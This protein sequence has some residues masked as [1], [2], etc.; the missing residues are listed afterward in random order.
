M[1]FPETIALTTKKRST[2]R[3]PPPTPKTGWLPPTSYPNLSAANI[4]GFDVETKEMDFDAGPGW[5]RGKGH[6]VGFSLS[7]QD[8][9]G[10]RGKWYIPVRHE[11]EPEYNLD[12]VNSFNWLRD[13]LGNPSTLKVGANIIYDIGWLAE[14]NVEVKGTLYD[15][16]FAEALLHEDG[17]VGLDHLANKY[18]NR[19]KVTDLLYK[20]CSDA[21]GGDVNSKQR[22]NIYRASP[23]LVGHYGED[24]ADLPIEIIAHQYPLM[25]KEDLLPVFHMECEL[26]PL[27]VAMRRTGVHVD[28]DRAAELKAELTLS[29]QQLNDEIWRMVGFYANVSSGKDLAKAFNILGIPYKITSSGNPSFNKE[30]LNSVEHPFGALIRSVR[31]MQSIRDTFIQSYILDKNANGRV[32][33]SFHPLR[34]DAGGT[35]SGRFSSSDPNLQNIPARTDL[36]KKVRT[37][38]IPDKGHIAW[39]KSDY[40][41]IEYRMLAHFAVGNGSDELRAEY[42]NNPRTDYHD[43][44][45]YRLCPFMGWDHNDAAIRKNYRKPV[46]NINFGLLYGMGLSKLSR[47]LMEYFSGS[48][49]SAQIKELFDAY[50]N[51]NPYVK[52]T[53]D[54]VA[55]F[56]QQNGYIATI[57]GRRSRFNL[58]EPRDRFMDSRPAITYDRALREY[59]H[60]IIRAD[61]HKAV[62]R[63]LQGSAAD[64]IKMGMLQCWKSGVFDVIG[65]P[66]L[67]VHD[68]LDFSVPDDSPG[69][70]E[71]FQEMQRIMETAIPL[72][73]PV[74][75]DSSRGANWGTT[76]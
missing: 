21:Y 71:G 31:E 52:A 1:F 13:V 43:N 36:G 7:A 10:N 35:R 66:K 5:A 58:W 60:G 54:S 15:V 32:H 39:Q 6:I 48:L 55:S 12:P 20:W 69:I 75:L 53:M 2:V 30:F 24:D 3:T 73:V 47:A 41:Q 72:R 49:S 64:M 29:I 40:S 25:A 63:L 50:H 56:A 8:S 28:L 26:I 11:V 16:Q 17:K 42:L 65:V 14:E 68:E 22:A 9:I 59:G 46:K 70:R 38:F 44:T 51:A 4:I 34:A 61:S 23:R 33:C 57:S 27:I 37:V 74:L 67:Q 19:H 45:F 62:N 18:T 76:D